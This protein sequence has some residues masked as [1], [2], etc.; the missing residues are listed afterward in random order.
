[1]SILQWL[2]GA[3]TDVPEIDSLD[4]WWHRHRASCERFDSTID[5]ALAA[6]FDADRLGY[7]FASGYQCAGE[8]MFGD[9][10]RARRAAFCATEGGR[11]DPS[12]MATRLE[13]HDGG[14][15]LNGEKSFVTFGAEAEIL[16]VVA[17]VGTDA[18]GRNRLKVVLLE[19]G[20]GIELER[21]EATPFV[22]E[23]PHASVRFRDVEVPSD[24]VLEGDGYDRYLKPFRTVEDLHVHA[25]A[26]AWLLR[27]ARRGALEEDAIETCLTAV[28]SLRQ[29]ASEDPFR[30]ETHLALAGTMAVT[31]RFI[32]AMEPLFA[33]SDDTTRER[34]Q[35]DRPLLSVAGTARALRREAAWRRLRAR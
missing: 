25:A 6:G 13:P 3:P 5:A 23:I 33:R 31:R 15:K 21:L 22:P 32:E 26:I 12:A 35:R 8:A 16:A 1:M 18:S 9:R 19:P 17:S 20:P 24:H 30:P 28:S 27:L 4:A 34:W 10:L 2:L 14:W 29:L 7:A 11:T